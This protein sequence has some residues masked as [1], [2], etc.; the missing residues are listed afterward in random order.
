LVVNN[1]TVNVF[2]H[3]PILF[4]MYFLKPILT[5]MNKIIEAL[6]NT[7]SSIIKIII[8]RIYPNRY[9]R[10]SWIKTLFPGYLIV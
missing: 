2:S 5:I 7:Q 9:N 6:V 4:I 3:D 1:A 10:P 8:I